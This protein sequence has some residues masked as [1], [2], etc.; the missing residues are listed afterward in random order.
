MSEAPVARRHLDLAIYTLKNDETLSDDLISG[1]FWEE[2]GWLE[3]FS[4]NTQ[5]LICALLQVVKY[6]E[7][8]ARFSALAARHYT[9]W[10]AS[11]KGDDIQ[12]AIALSVIA[13]KYTRPNDEVR[14]ERLTVVAGAIEAKA[15]QDESADDYSM[16]IHFYRRALRAAEPA[17][18][19]L[20]F[21]V[22]SLANC[23]RNR[24]VLLKAPEDLSEA[25]AHFLRGLDISL[26]DPCHPIYLSDYGDFLRETL[27]SSGIA[28]V[29]ALE[30]AVEYHERAINYPKSSVPIPYGDI[31]RKAAVAYNDLV[32]ETW[33][34][35]C[36]NRC[37]QCYEGCIRLAQDPSKS[38]YATTRLECANH[39]QERFRVWGGPKDIEKAI[40]LYDTVLSTSFGRLA[41]T[42]GKADALQ[43]VADRGE[44]VVESRRILG[45]ACE[46]ADSAIGMT[47]ETD[48]SRGLA[49][50]RAS[51]KYC[52]LYNLTGEM[53][54]L[55]RA[56]EHAKLSTQ[57][58]NNEAAWDFCRW[59]AQVC[60][61]RYVLSQSMEDINQA[62][63][64]IRTAI[65]LL[66]DK[67]TVNLAFCNW[68]LGQCFLHRYYFGSDAEDLDQA[69]KQLDTA[70]VTGDRDI[71]SKFQNDLANALR[72]KFQQTC[73]KED[74]DRA[75]ETFASAIDNVQKLGLPPNH[76][77]LAMLE[78]GLGTAMLERYDFWSVKEDLL[79]A[80]SHFRKS[81]RATDLRSLHYAGRSCSLSG[82]LISMF[83]LHEDLKWL[84]E[85]QSHLL[86]VLNAPVDIGLEAS[87]A[88]NATLGS[89]YF[90][91][92]DKTHNIDD[93]DRAVEYYTIARKSQGTSGRQRAIAVANAGVALYRK[94]MKSG[95]F[96]DYLE[97]IACLDEALDSQSLAIDRQLAVRWN[98]ADVYRA[99]V[100]HF[101]EILYWGPALKELCDLASETG[102]RMDL[103][104]KAAKSAARVATL[105]FPD[106]RRAYEQIMTAIEILPQAMLLYSSRIEQLRYVRKY[107]SL[108]STAVALGISAE[109]PTT[110]LVLISEQARAFVWDR[111]LLP[112]T[113]LETLRSAH[114]ELASRFEALRRI[115]M[116]EASDSSNTVASSL[117]LKDQ[118]RLNRHTKADEYSKL[119]HTIRSQDGFED[120]LLPSLG[121]ESTI[122]SS[123]NVPIVYLNI[124]E[125]RCDAII[126]RS[127]HAHT[128]TLPEVRLEDVKAQSKRLYDAQ[129]QLAG[130][131]SEA[132]TFFEEVMLWLW[133]TIAKP[134]LE[135]L[136][137]D[138][139]KQR[140][141]KQ[142]VYWISSGWLSVLPIHAAGDWHSSGPN[143][144]KPSVQERVVSS[145]IPSI[146][147]LEFLRKR[148]ESLQS[149][150]D[151]GEALLVGM[152][153]TPHMSESADL[154]AD[155]EV[156]A[157]K[158]VVEK[159]LPTSDHLSPS[160]KAILPSLRTCELVHFAC[161][162][163]A[164][165]EDPSKSALRLAD[166]QEQPLNVRA[167]MKL[168][169]E[170]CQLAFLTA[171]ETAANK[172]VLLREEGLHVAGA[173]NMA[174]VPHVV[175]GM[176]KVSDRASLELVKAFY[177]ELF[178][179]QLT[180]GSRYEATAEALHAS[181]D[182]LRNAGYH[183]VL[184][185]A[186]V[187]MGP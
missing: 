15:K 94:G 128:L 13:I 165:A 28:K 89:T 48:S 175:A 25:N 136:E 35:D 112:Q 3:S 87:L 92:Y 72:Y 46:L 83:S 186:F 29:R 174:G 19:A 95:K 145:Y 8:G 172:D 120:F 104:L 39:L 180:E 2:E 16:A 119:L 22:V 54:L 132:C 85:A 169:F 52:N 187:H 55:D 109:V 30:N 126:V 151:H 142:R 148:A 154:E 141:G 135:F 33:E 80:I 69:L 171:C 164:D 129:S 64:S 96:E 93:L 123:Q 185:G 73:S 91:V 78:S 88:V 103:R 168:P 108:P 51:F 124:S 178:S 62:F 23:L 31:W 77:R 150:K 42:I 156:S 107:H 114:P 38:N 12:A 101:R 137:R 63:T 130:S 153:H 1:R 50:H 36:S 37:I 43:A 140:R 161:H 9:D 21:F 49:Y 5:A 121:K 4:S 146:R 115:V 56:V 68:V 59:H 18:Q 149:G 81:L 61:D 76:A 102:M 60:K 110:H 79:S 166:W 74:L 14:P 176:W 99:I 84:E 65:E 58:T 152:P 163:L 147:V 26:D 45:E 131:F 17:H 11:R 82:A 6:H 116:S 10:D 122:A 75:I 70:C 179:R 162:G 24:W 98:R 127:G 47:N 144:D 133:T 155:V 160:F 138:H 53:C 139:S 66:D 67:D 125:Y 170:N 157:V 143:Q 41:A 27:G 40:R 117:P 86:K 177:T 100:E 134:I 181:V 167:L 184:W 97:S 32:R 105:V 71:L 90:S 173:F 57:Y 182:V 7:R 106:Y 113:P 158:T 159:N 20:G 183:P 34:P 111:V 118:S 44:D